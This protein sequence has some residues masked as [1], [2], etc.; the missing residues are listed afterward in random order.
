MT[1]TWRRL[2]LYLLLFGVIGVGLEL[3]LLEHY[4]DPWQWAPIALLAL[5]LVGGGLATLRPSRPVLRT[6]QALMLGY[7]LAGGLGMYL[8][9]NANVEFERELRPS[10]Q[11]IEL[12]IETLRGA[13]PV[14]APGA[15]VQLGLLGLLATYKHPHLNRSEPG[16]AVMA[17]S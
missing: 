17:G 8:H 2:A 12:V 9:L 10:M 1:E 15:M 4:E 13:M 5:G 11:G 14:L 3:V 7:V 6:L 16:D